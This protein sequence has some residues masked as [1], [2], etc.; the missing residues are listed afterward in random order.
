MF[1]H[2]DVIMLTSKQTQMLLKTSTSLHNATPVKKY[3]SVVTI[4]AGNL[5]GFGQDYYSALNF[6]GFPWKPCLNDLLN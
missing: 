1:N 6:L 3:L 2:S 4:T 5:E